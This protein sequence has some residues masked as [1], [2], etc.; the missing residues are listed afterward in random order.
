MPYEVIRTDTIIV[1]ILV[2]LM[3]RETQ[4][5]YP[6]PT[7]C[8]ELTHLKR[9]WCWERLK[10]GGEGD[11]RGWD[12]CM[13]SLT[14]W[15]WV[16]VRSRSWWWTGRPGVLQS[17]GLQRVGHVWMTELNWTEYLEILH[18]PL[19]F[20]TILVFYC[21][22]TNYL[23]WRSFSSVQLRLTLCDPMDCITPC[24]PVLHQLTELAQT[25]VHRVSDAMQPSHPLSSSSPPAFSLSQHQGLFQWVS[26]L[27]QVAKVLEF[28][29]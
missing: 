8:K 14:R 25:H 12:G 4:V 9:P 19:F 22:I 27:A 3:R 29:L 15:T 2:L 11:D 28:Q 6:R 1:A 5:N 13:A 7:W 20:P 24:F 17:M 23:S 10:A 21:C 18:F 26:S 16:W